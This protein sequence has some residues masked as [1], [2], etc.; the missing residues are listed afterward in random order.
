MAS[1]W[2]HWVDNQGNLQGP[3]DVEQLKKN[4][5]I[6]TSET[7]FWNGSSLSQWTALKDIPELS[8]EI[9]ADSMYVLV[10]SHIKHQVM[11]RTYTKA[12]DIF[13]QWLSPICIQYSYNRRD[14][15]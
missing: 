14:T 7:W 5:N 8:T 10:C 3:H 1:N 12:E 2:W 4:R 9:M 15:S 6:I 11:S 13:I